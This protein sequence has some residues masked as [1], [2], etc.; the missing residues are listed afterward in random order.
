MLSAALILLSPG[1]GCYQALAATGEQ[2]PGIEG[3]AKPGIPNPISQ[4]GN[5]STPLDLGSAAGVVTDRVL[6]IGDIPVLAP[7]TLPAPFERGGLEAGS[8]PIIE[9]GA[10]VTGAAKSNFQAATDGSVAAEFAKPEADQGG[11]LD[12]IFGGLRRRGK[13]NPATT[14]ANNPDTGRPNALAPATPRPASAGISV[15]PPVEDSPAPTL[16]QREAK[17]RGKSLLLVGTEA[18]APLLLELKKTAETLGLELFVV[19]VLKNRSRSAD[20]VAEDHFIAAPIDALG[21]TKLNNISKRLAEFAKAYPNHAVLDAVLASGDRYSELAGRIVDATGAIGDSA[22]VARGARDKELSRNIFS[23]TPELDT[24]YRTKIE[25]PEAARK[26]FRGMGGDPVLLRSRRTVHGRTLEV[27]VSEDGA[28][29][30]WDRIERQAGQSDI[31]MERMWEGPKV[32]VDIVVHPGKDGKPEAII[33]EVSD[34]SDVRGATFPSQLEPKHK[35]A[36]AKIALL[37]VEKFGFKSGS[38]RVQMVLTPE[39]PKVLDIQRGLGDEFV[40]E[41]YR[42]LTGVGFVEQSVR[43]LFGIAV[44]QPTILD[45][46]AD[47]KPNGPNV[48]IRSLDGH[49]AKRAS[50]Y[51]EDGVNANAE[52]DKVL[53]RAIEKRERILG[54]YLKGQ[55]GRLLSMVLYYSLFPPFTRATGGEKSMA[56][57]RIG[58][59]WTLAAVNPVAGVLAEHLSARGILVAAFL[60]RTVIWA[61]LVPGAFFL[62]GSGWW[63]AAALLG[64]NILDGAVVSIGGL[65]DTDEGGIDILARQHHFPVDGEVRTGINATIRTVSAAARVVIAPALAGLAVFL[66]VTGLLHSAAVAL[67]VVMAISF[68]LPAAYGVVQYLRAIPKHFDHGNRRAEGL[69]QLGSELKAGFNLALEKP[70]IHWRFFL[71]ALDRSIVDSMLFV[72]LATFGMNVMFPGEMAVDKAWGAFAATALVGIGQLGTLSMIVAIRGMGVF[73]WKPPEEGRPW[74]LGDRLMSRVEKFARLI[75]PQ[76]MHGWKGPGHGERT[77]YAKYRDFFPLLFRAAVATILIP[78]GAELTLH[79]FFWSGAALAALGSFLF[80]MYFTAPQLGLGNLMQGVIAEQGKD[81]NG[82]DATARLFAIQGTIELAASALI[83]ALMTVLFVILRAHLVGAMAIA[84]GFYI[85]CGAFTK[86]IA[87][88]LLFTHEER[89]ESD[90]TAVVK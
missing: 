54:G 1:L 23:Q 63:F 88:R 6:P 35:K 60:A 15:T 89:H 85:V 81:K 37:A 55:I 3:S 74:R 19:D 71:N 31:M 30:S 25:S 2:A 64:L 83:T 36:L 9:S 10:A 67:A 46:D 39:G 82:K 70:K 72:M 4:I 84:S 14:A 40:A 75:T 7:G 27:A 13:T 12:R 33:A 53:T 77:T 5:L 79:G 8:L 62:L 24:T 52:Y 49:V 66:T 57:G 22:E 68:L 76:Q 29:V 16:A 80:N 69:K 38:A 51:H 28:G 18:S 11:I 45:N 26:A 32:N 61:G 44:A 56:S 50:D 41:S 87:K 48:L 73:G 21:E 58:Y 59:A 17:V 34:E 20:L 43:S 65:L 47:K 90:S 42:N 86:Y 78:L